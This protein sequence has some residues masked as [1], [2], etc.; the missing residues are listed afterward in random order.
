MLAS[1]FSSILQTELPKKRGKKVEEKFMQLA[2]KEAQ[3]SYVKDEVPIGAVIE[4]DGVVIAKAHN[5]RN[6]T[7]NAI[8]HAEIL[9]ISK[10]CKK[11][12]SWRLDDCNIYVTLEPCPMCAGAILNARIKN[13][14]F[15]AYDKTSKTNL[16]DAI[17]QDDRLNHKTL[18]VGGIMQDE[19]SKLLTSF[20]AKIRT[21]KK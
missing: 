5:T 1:F 16:L 10:A 7:Q 9:A 18:A 11:L 17:L 14:Y 4:Y 2:L 12:K 6:K 13:L 20:F 3:K 19:C 8:N 21:N 15:G